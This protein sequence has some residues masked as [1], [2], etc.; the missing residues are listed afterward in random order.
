MRHGPA[1]GALPLIAAVALAACGARAADEEAIPAM[2]FLMAIDGNEQSRFNLA[3]RAAT[4][5]PGRGL[6][7]DFPVATEHLAPGT[8]VDLVV[9]RHTGLYVDD[10]I[11][12]KD[13]F[14][15]STTTVD[16]GGDV[17]FPPPSVAV[18]AAQSDRNEVPQT[19]LCGETVFLARAVRTSPGNLPAHE[20]LASCWYLM[21][22]G[23]KQ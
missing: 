15:I 4:D 2:R 3:W 5:D 23:C 16:A 6:A 12:V 13:S 17:L 18:G 19:Y 10:E 8:G 14:R 22:A 7:Y 21:V 9:A 20:T 11:V 1:R